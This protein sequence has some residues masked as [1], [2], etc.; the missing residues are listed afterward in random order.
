LGI[1]VAGGATYAGIDMYNDYK[2]E[3]DLSRIGKGTPAVV[4]VHD[5]HCSMCLA[6]Q[7]ETRRAMRQF[8]Q[9]DLIYVVADISQPEGQVFA[10]RHGVQH[11]TL[12]LMDGRGDVKEVLSG[13]RQQAELEPVLK[14]HFEANRF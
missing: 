6:L 4:Q 11:V 14:A 1:A 2:F 12:V 7:N 9:D 13:V 10:R 5:P 8:G 3:H